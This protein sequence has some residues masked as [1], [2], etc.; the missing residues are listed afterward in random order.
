VAPSVTRR[1]SW[2]SPED[3]VAKLRRRWETGEFLAALALRSPWEPLAVPLRTPTAPEL[4]EHFG[5]AQDWVARWQRV[6]SGL[7]RLE[8]KTIGGRLIGSN[9][10]PCRVLVDSP[11]QLWALLGVARQVET[12]LRLLDA[13][14]TA[15]PAL[16]DWMTTYPIK[17][18]AHEDRWA[19]LVDTVVWID[20]NATPDLYLRQVDVPGVDT[21]FIEQ[22]RGLLA[23]LLDRQLATDRVDVTHP[24]AR[25]AER[26][27]FRTKP[28][29]VRLRALGHPPVV[30]DWPATPPQRA[31]RR[32]PAVLAPYS[33]ATLRVDELAA[34]PI[35][36]A[37]VFVVENET[38]YLALPA[39]A[40]AVA[41]FGGGYALPSLRPLQWLHDR[42]L[43]YWGDIDTHGFVILDRLRQVFPHARSILMDRDTLLG[44]RG[45][46]GREPTP[47]KTTLAH[48]RPGEADLYNDLVADT[49]GPSV[50]LEQER[51]RFG[52]V[53]RALIH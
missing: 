37:R 10:V 47:V 45:H 27:R 21:K 20:R 39:V 33:E 11:R 1:P 26:Y 51:V 29:Y 24:P 5:A 12:F 53:K 44:H 22:H 6:D 32:A 2:T 35:E 28:V 30:P 23:E 31:L 9:E 42:E 3:V 4:T 14:R 50:R 19:N 8:R 46:W 41:V 36:A 25:F 34:T 38:T 52:D 18:L 43:F 49:F 13:T 48:L 16:V 15:A 17:V 7:V 40:D